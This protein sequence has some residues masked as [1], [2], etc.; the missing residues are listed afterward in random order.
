MNY[1]MKNYSRTSIARLLVV[2]NDLRWYF[3]KK[4]ILFFVTHRTQCFLFLRGI[5]K[6]TIKEKKFLPNVLC[7]RKYNLKCPHHPVITPH[8][9][10]SKFSFNTKYAFFY[11][12]EERTWLIRSCT[13]G[14]KQFHFS[15]TQN[16]MYGVGS[17]DTTHSYKERT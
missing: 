6:K 7:K 16:K 1:G 5:E 17:S 9:D 12:W 4:S 14:R 15:S 10:P 2:F 3:K 11:L 13:H 8:I